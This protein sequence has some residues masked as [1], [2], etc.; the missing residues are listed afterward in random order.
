MKLCLALK[1]A[2][3]KIQ[4]KN[5]ESASYTPSFDHSKSLA[6]H[7][8]GETKFLVDYSKSMNKT[9]FCICFNYAY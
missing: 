6:R 3:E 9:L 1:N 8:E 4:F 5:F 2:D 7:T